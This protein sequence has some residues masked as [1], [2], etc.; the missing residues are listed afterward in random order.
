MS[1]A[2]HVTHVKHSPS[3]ASPAGVRAAFRNARA[4]GAVLLSQFGLTKRPRMMG[5]ASVKQIRCPQGH[6]IRRD[7]IVLSEAGI[8]CKHREPHGTGECGELLFVLAAT[9][10]KL[11]PDAQGEGEPSKQDAKRP[12]P[13]MLFVAEVTSEEIERIEREEMDLLEQLAYLG[14]TFPFVSVWPGGPGGALSEAA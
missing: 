3:P 5:W 4:L 11:P 14:A 2:T 7:T 6:H 1:S 12:D 8:R 9:R 10:Q 13:A